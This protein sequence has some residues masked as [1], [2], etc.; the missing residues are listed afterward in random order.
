MREH[1]DLL[2]A[3]AMQREQIISLREELQR[4]VLQTQ[5]RLEGLQKSIQVIKE[6]GRRNADRKSSSTNLDDRSTIEALKVEVVPEANVK[7]AEVTCP[8]QH[9]R[10]TDKKLT[11]KL[12][13]PELTQSSSATDRLEAIKR[14]LAEQIERK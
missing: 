1:H 7:T 8:P 9:L 5:Y 4:F 12:A 6:A 14:R 2:K 13:G 10:G 11:T 3:E